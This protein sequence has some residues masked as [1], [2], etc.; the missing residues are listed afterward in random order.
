M[1]LPERYV[2]L[3]G[4]LLGP[5]ES[6]RAAA[7]ADLW[8]RY[9]RLALTDQRLLCLERGGLRHLPGYYRLITFPLGELATVDIHRGRVQITLTLVLKSGARFAYGLPAFSKG[10][11]RFCAAMEAA[12]GNS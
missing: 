4:P 12:N 3:F 2:K 10:T 8:F 9:R 1:S 11:A 5:T 6:L 7:N